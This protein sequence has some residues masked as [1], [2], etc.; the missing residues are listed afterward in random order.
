M[1]RTFIRPSTHPSRGKGLFD[2]LP[3]FFSSRQQQRET[4]ESHDHINHQ[5][6]A[7]SM[8]ATG[9]TTVAEFPSAALEKVAMSW[10]KCP[11]LGEVLKCSTL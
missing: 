4:L 5:L 8:S 10:L 7:C 3:L 9:H 6:S 2:I 1:M 11:L